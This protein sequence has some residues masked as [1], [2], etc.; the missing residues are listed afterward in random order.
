M[1]MIGSLAVA[2]V[3]RALFLGIAGSRPL[4]YESEIVRPLLIGST[5]VAP[6]QLYSI[7]MNGAVL[8]VFAVFMF[9]TS[10][11]RSMRALA[12]KIGSS[13]CGE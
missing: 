5:A 4:R 1:A 9:R 8:G 10:A 6:A 2:M 7:A 11:G 3:M 13:K 12:C